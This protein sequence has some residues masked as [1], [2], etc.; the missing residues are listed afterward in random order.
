MEL[1]GIIRCPVNLLLPYGEGRQIDPDAVG[2]L[3][4]C[5]DRTECKREEED[6]FIRGII[7]PDDLNLIIS[8]LRTSQ[9]ALSHT[10]IQRQYPLLLSH[11]IACLDGRHR[12]RAAMRHK[13][14]SWWVVKLLC[15]QGTWI[16]F[17]LKLALATVD[18][19]LIQDKIESTSRETS[20]SDAEIYRLLRNYSKKSDTPRFK[21]RLNRLSAP[22]Q[23]SVKGFL[24][25]ERLV[26]GLD[27]L[28]KFPGV[29]AGLQFGNVH[30]HLALHIDENLSCYLQHVLHVWDFITNDDPRINATVDVET[31]R[32]LQFRAPISSLGDRIAINRMFNEGMLFEGLKDLDL[33]EQVRKRVLSI[34]VIIPSI[35][36]FHENMKYI[37]MGAKILR[38]YLMEKPGPAKGEP[39]RHK[40]TV[41]ESLASRWSAEIR[42]VEV[43]DGKV[44]TSHEAPTAWF[45][46]ETVFLAALREFARLS[47]DHPRQDVR[48]ETMPAFAEASRVAYLTRLAQQVGFNNSRIEETLER[49]HG[50]PT[51]DIYSPRDGRPADWRA[52]IPF[53]KSYC[54]LRQHAFFPQ[55]ESRVA[56]GDYITPLFVIRD[57]MNAFFRGSMSVM[58]EGYIEPPSLEFW[59]SGQSNDIGSYQETNTFDQPEDSLMRDA[60]ENEPVNE[61]VNEP[62]NAPSTKSNVLKR[63]SR[64][65]QKQKKKSQAGKRTINKQLDYLSPPRIDNTDVQKPEPAETATKESDTIAT[66]VV[67]RSAHL[68]AAKGSE[69]TIV[70]Q[71]FRELP[72]QNKPQAET[73]T[74]H[75]AQSPMNLQ[76]VPSS[77]KQTIDRPNQRSPKFP[78]DLE[79]T[80]IEATLFEHLTEDLASKEVIVEVDSQ[81]TI[82]RQ[83]QRSPHFSATQ[84]EPTAGESSSQAAAE[85]Q[86]EVFATDSDKLQTLQR[87]GERSPRFNSDAAQAGVTAEVEAGNQAAA[88]LEALED[89]HQNIKTRDQRSPPPIQ[90]K[91][92][93]KRGS[94]TPSPGLA[95]QTTTIEESNTLPARNLQR[96]LHLP[97]QNDSTLHANKITSEGTLDAPPPSRHETGQIAAWYPFTFG[98]FEIASLGREIPSPR[99][100]IPSPGREIPSL[101]GSK[102]KRE[103]TSVGLDSRSEL[104]KP[105]EGRE[106]VESTTNM[107]TERGPSRN[108]T[109]QGEARRRVEKR[110]ST[111]IRPVRAM[112]PQRPERME[113]VEESGDIIQRKPQDKR[114]RK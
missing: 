67:A 6:N 98:G 55:L 87:P 89:F 65:I 42:N 85:S 7:T 28:L 66:E 62:A 14:L 5:F 77:I 63:K 114:Q 78:T 52:G 101:A 46:Y 26:Q 91:S 59:S 80:P 61:P 34:Q 71:D 21:E 9:R 51:I 54:E 68:D 33:R 103:S 2:R 81:Q 49:P 10:I 58:Y 31:V 90:A 37:S 93:N 83:D 24:K 75:V 12:I 23:T 44:S 82:Q 22:K 72:S 70:R 27:A 45:A 69:Q 36:T 102:R 99:R 40:V 74:A 106:I 19:Q 76:Q 13:P 18:H 88:E 97:Q 35:E 95:E 48:G 108:L 25:R 11:H 64:R 32:C 109:I 20:Y 84:A 111:G 92:I 113:G 50:H 15:V 17:P 94:I 30:K 16:Q 56:R 4:K 60:D 107:N 43:T 41:F 1:V 96:T 53:T 100:E 112:L 39:R 86:T 8:T 38:K 3:A 47:P 57:T 104:T 105:E 79:S 29:V 110:V 73:E